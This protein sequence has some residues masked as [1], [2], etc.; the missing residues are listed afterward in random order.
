M[1]RGN[2]KR[3]RRKAEWLSMGKE[4]KKKQRRKYQHVT[5][6]Q[7]DGSE[8]AI[9]MWVFFFHSDSSIEVAPSLLPTPHYCDITGL[10]AS[11]HI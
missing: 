9:L 11:H 3:Q 7:I 6:C 1:S 10:E 5:T 8:A 4:L 2:R